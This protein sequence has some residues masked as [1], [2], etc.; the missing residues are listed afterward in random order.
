VDFWRSVD[1][2]CER[3][4]PGLWSEPPNAASNGL[5]AVVLWL[6]A[7]GLVAVKPATG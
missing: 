2:Y 3:T 7:T 6:A 5:N 4:D 1:R